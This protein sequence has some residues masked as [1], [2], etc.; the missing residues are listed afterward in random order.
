MS[1]EPS[2]GLERNYDSNEVSDTRLIKNSSEFDLEIA[3]LDYD[4]TRFRLQIQERM[5]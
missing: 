5:S 3:R 4:T 2:E 1:L